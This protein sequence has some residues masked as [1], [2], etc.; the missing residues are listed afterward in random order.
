M[1]ESP[2]ASAVKLTYAQ[3]AKQAQSA[4]KSPTTAPASG[5]PP[6]GTAAANSRSSGASTISTSSA[7]STLLSS[8][9]SSASVSSA[10]DA[11]TPA[12]SVVATTRPSSPA[13]QPKA[14]N[15][16]AQ[17]SPVSRG[18]SAVSPQRSPGVNVWALRRERLSERASPSTS[19]PAAPSTQ[20]EDD[21]PF[22]VKH[23]PNH[24]TNQWS[25][26][27][28]PLPTVEDKES[29]PEIGKT[30]PSASTSANGGGHARSS[31]S[32][33]SRDEEAPRASS[34]SRKGEKT[35]WIPIPAEELQAA[36]DAN[37]R[38]Q[39]RTPQARSTFRASPHAA[40]ASPHTA[41]PSSMHSRA[42]SAPGSRLSSVPHSR[43]HSVIHSR[44]QSRVGS[45]HNSPFVGGTALP[46]GEGSNKVNGLPDNGAPSTNGTLNPNFAFGSV[47][48]S[49]ETS[50][51]VPAYEGHGY[52]LSLNAHPFY[53]S[54]V[55][56]SH[57]SP[58]SS[59][60]PS[61][62][63]PP[64]MGYPSHNHSPS[65]STHGMSPAFSLPPHAL[66]PNGMPPYPPPVP[67]FNGQPLPNAPFAPYPYGASPPAH[68]AP[69]PAHG[70]PPSA[71]APHASIESQVLVSRTPGVEAGLQAPAAASGKPPAPQESAAVASY[72][73]IA[74][75]DRKPVVVFGSI[76]PDGT[77]LNGPLS[78]QQT[79]G[80]R[81]PS[82]SLTGMDKAFTQFTIGV[83]REEALN[84][85]EKENVPVAGDR[86]IIDLTGQEP[87]AD[88]PKWHFGSTAESAS[89][90]TRQA[91]A[92]NGTA[93]AVDDSAGA[94][95]RDV[96]SEQP[97]DQEGNAQHGQRVPTSGSAD[98]DLEVKDFGYGFGHHSGTGHA[99]IATRE[100]LKRREQERLYEVERMQ[101][102]RRE[103]DFSSPEFAPR[104]RRGG[105]FVDRPYRGRGRGGRG[106]RGARYERG[107]G[108][109]VPRQPPSPYNLSP[110]PPF[111][112]LMMGESPS[113]MYPPYV[114]G[115]D[116]FAPPLP[117]VPLPPPPPPAHAVPPVA[118]GGIPFPSPITLVSFPLDPTRWWLLGQLE[119]YVSPQNLATD[120]FLRQRMTP[121]GWIPIQLLASFKRVRQLTTDIALVR[122]VLALSRIVYVQG[123]WVR[124]L[125]WQQ[126]VLPA[127][128]QVIET[129]QTSSLQSSSPP[130]DG[131]VAE[132][133]TEPSTEE[134]KAP[135][136]Q[137][138]PEEHE[139]EE[140]EDVVFVL[141]NE[142]S[143]TPA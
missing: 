82:P 7:G 62:Y 32:G 65:Y 104:G 99:V 50:P 31:T 90:E 57:E 24:W 97:L 21:D 16:D 108:P 136:P 93:A 23:R 54:S 106:F 12:S 67:F 38:R 103:R 76:G 49:A 130:Q 40:G 98:T 72:R 95:P 64:P 17:N 132:H 79:G 78:P 39:G 92:A 51:R 122:D 126:Y 138:S 131:G 91:V 15:G 112:P 137:P 2:S 134:Q 14:L 120:F 66:P 88:A 47:R 135:Q 142:S 84:G 118:Q 113:G 29:W 10:T 46:D 115:F 5:P 53:P 70:A 56:P 41:G 96:S 89:G 30:V 60:A 42:P 133:P 100:G 11:Y 83:K 3:R 1:A 9:K 27:V 6:A 124:P 61:P 86:E 105:G 121:E 128:P 74:D 34:S 68:V 59:H 80:A 18:A 25:R 71:H 4:S 19:S 75:N 143:F 140:E 119:Y 55:P 101:V 33:A 85:S 94:M 114:P 8:S 28:A 111:Q 69:P 36:A 129:P 117:P 35:K 102:D 116:A 87:A 22:V 109:V 13:S 20:N 127:Q 26:S 58:Y 125:A 81:V 141:G 52:H 123:D 44:N 63:P 107:G 110:V 139:E 37:L 48:S 77:Q 43:T 45:V 73:S